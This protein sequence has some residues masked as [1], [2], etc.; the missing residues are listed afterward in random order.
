MRVYDQLAQLGHVSVAEGQPAALVAKQGRAKVLLESG[1]RARLPDEAASFARALHGGGWL[2]DRASFELYQHEM[3]EPWG[4]PPA[5]REA[6]RRADAVGELW[7]LWRRGE[8]AD[9]GRR[10]VGA[11][12]DSTLAIW[13]AGAHDVVAAF[14]TAEQLRARW[15]GLWED[16]GLTIAV[17]RIDGEPL[18]GGPLVDGVRPT[19]EARLPFTLRVA[20]TPSFRADDTGR[21]QLVIA[22]IVLACVLTIAASYGLYR[23]TMR[24]LL[25]A[26]QQSDFVAAVSH[27]F[28]TPL[29]SMR[30]LLDLLIWRGVRDDERKVHYYG[31]LAGETGRSGDHCMR[32]AGWQFICERQRRSGQPSQY[33]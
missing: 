33:P 12:A 6:I 1:D 24:E 14:L 16:R 31:L 10:V 28:R 27:E 29:T 23:I 30:H 13:R 22:V 20:T 17:S 15:R 4:G 2:I 5:D 18:F 19:G 9:R 32:D 7:R 11:A 3:I 25:L 8:L 21:P 26:R